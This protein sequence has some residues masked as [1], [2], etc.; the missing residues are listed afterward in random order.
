MQAMLVNAGCNALAFAEQ[1]YKIVHVCEAALQAYFCIGFFI[2][3]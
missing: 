3:E 1:A 2:G